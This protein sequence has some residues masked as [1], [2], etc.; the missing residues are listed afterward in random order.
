MSAGGSAELLALSKQER[1]AS[2]SVAAALKKQ[3]MDKARLSEQ[4]KDVKHQGL[5][6]KLQSGFRGFVGRKRVWSLKHGGRSLNTKDLNY[7]LGKIKYVK[8]T[9][10]PEVPDYSSF[11]M[12]PQLLLMPFV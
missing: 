1:T 2:Q 11:S 3:E 6:M 4:M 10:F 5:V 12:K 8:I 7:G 9:S